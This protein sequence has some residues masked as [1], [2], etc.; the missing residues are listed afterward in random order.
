VTAVATRYETTIGLEVHVQLTTRSKM[1][2]S[3]SADYSGAPPNTHVCPVCLGAPGVLPVINE[4]AI[5]LIAITG[6]A[7]DCTI[8]PFSKFDR[9][10]YPYPDLPKGYQISQYD[11]PICVNGH[12]DVASDVGERRIGITRIHMEEDTARLL[13]RV[14]STTG[15]AYSLVD[16]NRAGSPLMEV[17]SEP[18]ITTA[19]E[20]RE[21]LVRLRQIFRYIGVSRANMEEGQ[22]RCDANV[23]LRTPGATELGAKVEIKNMNSFKAVHDALLFEE[24]RQAEGLDRGERIV[25]ETR[26]WVDE[27]GVTV[28]QRT[29][30]EASDYRYFPEPDLPPL[31][32]TDAYILHLRSQIPELPESRKRRFMALGLSDH[33]AATVVETRERAEYF[34]ALM[35]AISG[36]PVRAAKLASNWVLGEVGHWA[37]ETGLEVNELRARPGQLAQLVQM[38][39]SGAITA[40]NAKEVFAE[41]A[42]SGDDPKSIVDQRGLATIDAGDALLAAAREAIEGN[43][44]AVDDYRAGKETAINLLVGKV[45]QQTRGRANPQKVLEILA[46]ELADK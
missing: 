23:S 41:M 40:A 15:E 4:R 5:E 13:H 10:N 11:L 2:C 33:E 28:S 31:R 35:N 18:D 21:Y 14:D 1:F 3:C 38:V 6:L 8:A 7:L 36:E 24:T 27:R 30:E 20:A 45:M 9:K 42:T 44:R 19:A 37:N 16:L 12:L 46:S 25:Q 32:F 17:V 29:K 22:M 34:E 26:G 39:E 43:P